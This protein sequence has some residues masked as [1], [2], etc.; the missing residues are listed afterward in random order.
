MK[1]STKFIICAL[2]LSVALL[3]LRLL[4]KSDFFK[5]SKQ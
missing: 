4:D 5:E 1:K 2:G 3:A